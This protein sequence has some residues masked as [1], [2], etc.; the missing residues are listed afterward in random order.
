MLRNPRLFLLLQRLLLAAVLC[1]ALTQSPLRAQQAQQAQPAPE[2]METPAWF[3][4]TFLDIREDVREAAKEGRRLLV[5]FGQDGCPYCKEL[6][7]TNFT[8]QR[9]VEKTRRHFVSLALN[10]WGD[11]EVT[12]TDGRAMNE[13]EFARML[14]VQFTPTILL[15]D[16]QGAVAARLNGY[17]PPHRFEAAIDYAAGKLEKKQAFGE[18]MK[19]AV[20]EA[21]SDRL[22]DEPFFIKPP[23]ALKRQ[24]GGKPLLA[25]FETRHCS[26]CDDLHREG[27]RR[28]EVGSQIGRFDVVRLALGDTAV[29]TKPDGKRS[30]ADAWARELKVNYT[31]T[32]VFFDDRGRE[33]LRVEAYLRPF[34]LASALAYVAEGGYRSEPS[35]Q[36]YIQA[37]AGQ[38]RARGERVELWQ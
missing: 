3:T 25:L 36:R 9:I 31:P 33:V 15:F 4:E 21:A 26:G 35:F 1:G 34:H 17:Y 20:K 18:Y 38:M 28:P 16:E 13:K 12:W 22:H 11:R 32:L 10:I 6:V 30:N 2:P 24:P 8:Q 7:R 27:F 23:Y 29:L 19:T 37:R 5:Y 14:K